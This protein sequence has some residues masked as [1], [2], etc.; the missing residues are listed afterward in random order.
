MTITA[1]MTEHMLTDSPEAA[2]L[3]HGWLAD[4]RLSDAVP[5]AE[6]LCREH[7][8]NASRPK[9]LRHMPGR[10]VT[11]MVSSSDHQIAVLKVFKSPRA[12]GNHRRLDELQRTCVAAALPAAIAV[13]PSGRVGLVTF[14]PGERFDQVDDEIFLEVAAAAGQIL[15]QLH[16]SAAELDR[17]WTFTDEASLLRLR[18]PNS[19]L[20]LVEGVLEDAID[21]GMSGVAGVSD[22]ASNSQ[23]V[24]SHRDFHPRQIIVNRQSD[25]PTVHFIDLDDAAMA[26]AGL[27]VGNMIAHLH[28]E[29]MLSLR[30]SPIV[31]E[32]I[33]RF[34]L[35]YGEL[36]PQVQMWERL[37][38]TR[39][40][41][42]AETRHHDTLQRDRLAALVVGLRTKR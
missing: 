39:L 36:P 24:P 6:L 5:A 38:L 27:D 9:T 22:A 20:D 31:S 3:W 30:T 32:A 17:E 19:L 37:A 2:G 41:C 8:F 23:L 25:A 15:R 13:D 33:E 12:R 18:V 4:E 28:R 10:R 7:G 42:L 16:D 29:A 40:A 26:P 1:N 34:T 35:G 21:A 11:A 14:T